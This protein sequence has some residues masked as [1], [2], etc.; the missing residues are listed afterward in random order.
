MRGMVLSLQRGET[1][2]RA[3][4]KANGVSVHVIAGSHAVLLAMNATAAAA[5]DLAGFAVGIQAAPEPKWLK[6]FKFFEDLVPD[7]RPGERRST[8]EHPVQSFLWGH[9]SARPNTQYDYVVR[10]LYF[11]ADGNLGQLRAG[12]DVSVR[13]QT[14][15]TETGTH[16][17]FFNRGAIVS[18]A[19]ADEFGNRQPADVNDIGARDVQWLSRGLLE[20]ALAF[21]GQA[22]DAG[23]EIRCCFYEL[24]YKPILDALK[25]AAGRG[26]R[27]QV[28]YEAGHVTTAGDF[29]ET[30]IGRSNQLEV[31]NFLNVARLDFHR[32]TRHV[33]I[34]HNKFMILLRND[35]PQEVWTGSTNITA[36]G[37]LG[38]TN[39]G[40]VVRDDTVA[41]IFNDYWV[42]IARDPDRAVL[43]AW[44][45]DH[46]P[47]PA[48]PLAPRSI[49]PVFSPRSSTRMLD[50]Y[51]ARMDEADQSVMLTSAFGVTRE[52]A[53]HFDNDRDYLRFLLMESENESPETQAMLKRDRDT[54]IA[55][56]QA[57]GKETITRKI[58][59]WRLDKWFAQEEH[60]RRKGHVFYVHTKIMVIDPFTDDPLVFTGSANFSPASLTSND[61]NMLLIRGDTGV[62]DVYATEF[63]R[64]F[65]HF[66]FRT[67]ANAVASRG[68]GEDQSEEAVFL[69]PTDGWKERSFT[70]GTYHAR[71]RIL[72]GVDPT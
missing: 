14:E 17:I 6:G 4:A 69:D 60:F 66:Y 1:S 32:R 52:L 40:H 36:S 62:A 23:F 34:P 46:N 35:V 72:F 25:A 58:D 3:S 2:M 53:E 26:A 33:A 63:F 67:V 55:L 68:A 45:K 44:V 7:P 16:S 10:P 27:V 11:P 5:R 24:T 9:Y 57:L 51:G 12:T 38:Q 49:A 42:E 64:L 39:V 37:F 41:R 20:A 47:P 56:G 70:D 18:Q 61:E 50:W 21:I 30:T 19:F 28:I 8:L 65:N 43:K 71:R 48:G 54:R 15:P 31:D 13:V 59:G 22:A 29:E